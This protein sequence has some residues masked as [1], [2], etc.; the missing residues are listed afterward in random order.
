VADLPRCEVH[1]A[2]YTAFCHRCGDLCCPLCRRSVE[3]RL[4]CPACVERGYGRD[5]LEEFRRA[6]WGRPYDVVWVY[7]LTA[8]V[9]GL[10]LVIV[11]IV[12]NLPGTIFGWLLPLG[13]VLAMGF[14][15]S[16]GTRW[17]GLAICLAP[18]TLLVPAAFTTSSWGLALLLAVAITSL[19]NLQVLTSPRWRLYRRIPVTREELRRAHAACSNQL[20][21]AAGILTL[22][23]FVTLGVTSVPAVACAAIALTRVDLRAI[24]PVAGRGRAILSLIV[25]LAL[26]A[27]LLYGLLLGDLLLG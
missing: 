24:P 27:F 12:T 4:V 6:C 11:P 18:L 5:W 14:G 16:M 8:P 20:A 21:R 23:G 26:L 1:E 22:L 15:V 17:C 9:L 19:L 2:A 25:S 13:A 10:L 7:G 3:G